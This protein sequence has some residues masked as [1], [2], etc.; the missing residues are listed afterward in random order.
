MTT[1]AVFCMN[2]TLFSVE[3]LLTLVKDKRTSNQAFVIGIE[4]LTRLLFEE[5]IGRI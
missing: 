3:L 5:A 4:R 1:T 2:C